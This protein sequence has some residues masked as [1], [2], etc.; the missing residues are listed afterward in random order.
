M[1]NPVLKEQV[2]TERSPADAELLSRGSGEVMTMRGTLSATAVLFTLLLAGAA[3]G[4]SLVK[5][6]TTADGQREVASFPSWIM[7]VVLVGFGLVVLASF[8]PHL[9]RIIGP[10]Y[11]LIQGVFVG[12]IS[13]VYESAFQ[14]VV[15]QA[16]GATLAVFAVML[17]L[18]ASRT[19]R[20][21]DRL[22]SSIM[23]ATFGLMLFYGLSFLL[24]L[25][26][27]NISFI[28]DASLLGIAFSVFAAGLAAFNLLLDF[29]IIERG[30]TSRAPA[31]F[32]WFAALGVM[33]TVVW[34]YL[35]MLRLLAKLQRR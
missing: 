32:E 20:V 15:V 2:F 3:F 5:T 19:I 29:D 25:F 12:A 6:V 24:H 27:V 31:A 23:A 13:H 17:F 30:I 7:L 28:S 22:R 9:A 4:W 34:L 11:A 35:E 1:A 26:G 33:V 21:T 16:V 18:F 14:G 10:I 8:K